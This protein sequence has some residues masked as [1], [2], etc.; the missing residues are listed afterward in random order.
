MQQSPRDGGLGRNSG[1]TNP[2]LSRLELDRAPV[3]MEFSLGAVGAAGGFLAHGAMLTRAATSSANAKAS[4]PVVQLPRVQVF[5]S[6]FDLTDIARSDQV[7]GA[8]IHFIHR[9]ATADTYL[10]GIC[11]TAAIHSRLVDGR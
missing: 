6:E 7:F 9:V 5:W 10:S 4:Q 3:G 11:P 2:T 1:R 8:T